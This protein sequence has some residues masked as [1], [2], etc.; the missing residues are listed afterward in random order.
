MSASLGDAATRP[1]YREIWPWLLMLPPAFAVAGGMTMIYL[2]SNT[3][4]ALVVEDYARIEALT[5]Q[6]FERDRRAAELGVQAML[7]FTGTPTRVEAELTAPSMFAQPHTLLLNARH[8]TNPIADRELTLT[9][10]GGR[11]AAT[12]EFAPGHYRIELM[13]AD[14]SWRLGREAMR[15]AGTL[16]LT[17]QAHAAQD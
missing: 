16:V 10:D 12:A 8:A 11:Y 17:P 9:P 6:R 4:S 3:P 5:S 14:R 15:L 13:P 7:S 1:W 2:A